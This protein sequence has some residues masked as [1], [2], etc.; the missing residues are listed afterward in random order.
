MIPAEYD[1]TIYKGG[2]FII[3]LTGTDAV[4]LINFGALYDSALM[5]IQ[6]AWIGVNDPMPAEPLFILSTANGR[7]IIDGT[8]ITLKIPASV[9]KT[10]NFASG[11]YSLKLIKGG[12]EPIE[13]IMLKGLVSVENGATP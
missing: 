1:I 13:D 4:G 3:E 12:A 9:T 6:H 8:K 5:Y 10:I 7:I 11:V 2:T